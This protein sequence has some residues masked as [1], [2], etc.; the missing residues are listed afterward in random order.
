M[1]QWE[2]LRGDFESLCG[3]ELDKIHRMRSKGENFLGVL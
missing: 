3:V 1:S 2:L